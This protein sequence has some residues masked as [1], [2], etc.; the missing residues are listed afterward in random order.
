MLLI[1]TH[2]PLFFKACKMPIPLVQNSSG[3]RFEKNRTAV[4]APVSDLELL[5]KNHARLQTLHRPPKL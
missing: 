3:T 4:L 2:T 5:S 1:F